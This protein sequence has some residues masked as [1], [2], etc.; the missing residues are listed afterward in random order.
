MGRGG[1]LS[2]EVS[3]A[4]ANSELWKSEGG[5]PID[6]CQQANLSPKYKKI[7]GL[8]LAAIFLKYYFNVIKGHEANSFI[9]LREGTLET[10]ISFFS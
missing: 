6:W 7:W 3:T 4:N 2:A 10:V 5:G 9:L 8:I 1:P